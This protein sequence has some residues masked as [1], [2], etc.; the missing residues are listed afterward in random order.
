ME[1]IPPVSAAAAL[2]VVLSNYLHDCKLRHLLLHDAQSCS[3]TSLAALEVDLKSPSSNPSNSNEF[4][5]EESGTIERPVGD[6][7]LL[8]GEK[9]VID[10][11]SNVNSS[12][13]SEGWSAEDITNDPM[14]YV[15]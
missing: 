9:R 6:K 13:S 5:L 8:A 15:L 3:Q 10:C 12:Q 11:D 14:H 2:E 1:P 4:L 7:V